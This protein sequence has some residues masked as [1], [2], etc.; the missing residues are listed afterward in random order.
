MC[1]LSKDSQT[2]TVSV[3]IIRKVCTLANRRL[4]GN[5]RSA[6]TAAA[7]Y[8]FTAVAFHV[9]HNLNGDRIQEVP[10]QAAGRRTQQAEA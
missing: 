10:A 6:E 4:A 2:W 8:M 9:Q 7:A 3:L 1:T 5:H